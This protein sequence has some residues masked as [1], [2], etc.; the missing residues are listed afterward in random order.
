MECEQRK[1]IN[2]D[3]YK[4]KIQILLAGSSLPAL[5]LIPSAISVTTA[6]II[7]IVTMM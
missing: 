5:L 6:G 7:V 2:I 3:E 1:N 4:K